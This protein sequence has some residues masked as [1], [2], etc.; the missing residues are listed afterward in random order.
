MLRNRRWLLIFTLGIAIGIF[1]LTNSQLPPPGGN[2][3]NDWLITMEPE[4]ET[5]LTYPVWVDG[6]VEMR[7]DTIPWTAPEAGSPFS[8]GGVAHN[9]VAGETPYPVSAT[10]S[11]SIRVILTWLPTDRPAPAFVFVRLTGTAAYS[12]GS[13]AIGGGHGD[14]GLHHDDE[15][16]T[17]N[18]YLTGQSSGTRY[19]RKAVN[20]GQVEVTISPEAQA[21]GTG[22]KPAAATAGVSLSVSPSDRAVE[23]HA[24][25]IEPT[26]YRDEN[27]IPVENELDAAGCMHG[28][29]VAGPVYG[30]VAEGGYYAWFDFTIFRSLLGPWHAEP[31]DLFNEWWRQYPYDYISDGPFSE[32]TWLPTH[33]KFDD[34]GGGYHKVQELKNGPYENV[35]TYRATDDV[36]DFMAETKY[37]MKIH[38]PCELTGEFWRQE[39]TGDLNECP[40]PVGDFHPFM[41][42]SVFNNTGQPVEYQFTVQSSRSYTFSAANAFNGGIGI[43]MVAIK[44]QLGGDETHTTTEHSQATVGHT[45]SITVPPYEYRYVYIVALGQV[46]FPIGSK[47]VTNGFE[48]DG[49]LHD[50]NFIGFQL[51]VESELR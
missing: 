19:T 33:H 44:V 16:W 40:E 15:P 24:S 12:F 20:N 18:T 14:N 37:F 38:L 39:Y 9:M 46:T 26:Y 51:S 31:Q 13:G 23:L 17:T 21:N 42:G 2:G 10:C 35:I 22:Y 29:T 1:G 43:D 32:N 27:G 3:E 41:L 25:G 5:V 50:P 11:G 34:V 6:Q 47:Y 8:V 49:P 36:D 48:G 4:G 30:S 28:D 7:T 45:I